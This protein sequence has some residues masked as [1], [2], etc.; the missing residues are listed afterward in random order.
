M[1]QQELQAIA[2]GGESSEVEF[3]RTT[4]QRTDAAK[5]ACAMLNG[6]GGFVLF[7][8]DDDGS[9]LGQQVADT[10][11]GD[12]NRELRR[13]D[14]QVLL[15]P[16]VVPLEGSLSVIALRVPSGGLKP[17]TYKGR[18]Y[19][20]HGASTV[21]MDQSEYRR[22]LVEQMHPSQRW[23]TQVAQDITLEDLD[24]GE[25]VRTVDEAIRRSR[26]EDPGTRD[27]FEI[28]RG[29][30]LIRDDQILSAAVVLFVK[31]DNALP[32]YPQCLLRMARFR[33]T[34][35][36]EFE[37]NRQAH[38]NAFS[39]L[40]KAQSFLRQH[41]PVAGRVVPDL[42]ERVDDP[43]YPTEALREALANAFCHRDYQIGGGSVS[44]A[45]FDDRLEIV[46]A[47][48]LPFGLTPDDLKKPHSSRPWNP[49]IADV[50]YRRGIIEQWGRG[51]LKIAEL[52]EK[53]GLPEP[54]FE[55]RNGEVV[56][57][58][59][60]TGYVPPRKIDHELTPLQQDLLETVADVGPALLSTIISN[61][62][63]E[64]PYRTVQDNLRTLRE[65][66]LVRLAG[67]GRGARWSLEV[68]RP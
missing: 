24:A 55:D 18:P 8:V 33:G 60:P 21:V 31:P 66:G 2:A 48:G 58:F 50:F 59:F 43:L 14:P 3:K 12:V 30:R 65:L 17:Y 57:R 7:G 49:L 37:D 9:L 29:L 6:K 11:L 38:G 27:P 34:T 26:M 39:L 10:T 42:F 40:Q 25:I 32:G 53:A 68:R 20:R 1:N 63:E 36:S 61:L 67:H 35:T 51:T 22:M 56:V 15:Q 64:A 47:G 46:S 45:I 28:L 23:E 41:L 4:G 54:E 19:A 5:T 16:D 62:D 13:I 52:V 44:L